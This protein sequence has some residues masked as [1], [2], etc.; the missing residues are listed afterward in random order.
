M[1]MEGTGSE[2]PHRGLIMTGA[3]FALLPSGSPSRTKHYWGLPPVLTDGEDSRQALGAARVLVIEH[4][5]DGV[6]LNR[7]DID[8]Q[9]VGDTWHASVDDAREQAEFEYGSTKLGWVEVPPAVT[10]IVAFVLNRAPRPVH[11]DG[12]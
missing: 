2:P 5:S 7:Y 6:F 3:L 10:D 9:P 4:H 11:P 12:R 1:S 8:G